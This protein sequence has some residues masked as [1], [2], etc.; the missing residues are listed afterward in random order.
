MNKT[1][2]DFQKDASITSK[3]RN[4]AKKLTQVPIHWKQI[5]QISP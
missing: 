3:E 2:E 5:V 4:A 1:I